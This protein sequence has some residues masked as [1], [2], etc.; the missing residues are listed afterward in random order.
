MVPGHLCS[1][2]VILYEH[3]VVHLI[4]YQ[5]SILIV[6]HLKCLEVF[7]YS[8]VFQSRAKCPITVKCSYIMKCSSAEM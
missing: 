8:E 6:I 5:I 3:F 4:M 7:I 2:N 1:N